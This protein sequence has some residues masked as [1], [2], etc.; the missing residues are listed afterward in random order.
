MSEKRIAE[1]IRDQLSKRIETLLNDPETDIDGALITS[2][3]RWL[4]RE[5]TKP[6][7]TEDAQGIADHDKI[8]SKQ[9]EEAAKEVRE[10]GKLRR[11]Y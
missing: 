7:G 11:V 8:V 3:I 4:D 9:A 1:R 10:D 5:G 2:L 6:I